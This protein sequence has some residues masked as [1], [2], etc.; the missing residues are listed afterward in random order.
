[1]AVR[2]GEDRQLGGQSEKLLTLQET[3]R[4]LDITPDDV[5][6]LIREGKLTAFKLGGE[7]LRFRSSDVERLWDEM[8][9]LHLHAPIYVEKS[10]AQMTGEARKPQ[11][12]VDKFADFLYFNDFYIIG[13]LVILTL[14]AIIFAL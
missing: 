8:H 9:G 12:P 5:D 3:A 10:R 11:N 13:V 2:E 1:M 4:R 7:V 6:L 14:L